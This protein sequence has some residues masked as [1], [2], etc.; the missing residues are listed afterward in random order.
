MP[1]LRSWE[2]LCWNIRGINSDDKQLALN[3]AIRTSG[4]SVV[5]IQE[6]KK[7]T[8]DLSFIKSCCPRQFDQFAYVPSQGASGG[9]L[10]IWKSSLFTS[11]VVFSS[12]FALVI[13]FTSTLSSHSW[14]LANIYGP[15]SG[16]ARITFTNWL[17]N[18]DIPSSQ[19]WLLVGDF[20][21]IRVPDNR[22]KPGGA[23]QT[24]AHSMILSAS[25][26][27]LSYLSR[28]D[29]L[30]GVTCKMIPCLSNSTGSSR[31]LIGPPPSQTRW[32]YLLASLFLIMS[33]AS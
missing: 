21:Y 7:T 19:D 3:N 4:C 18:L 23:H 2:V 20:N 6:T 8:F 26:A 29:R 14:T 33:L 28:A 5:C 1:L 17:Y 11:V 31:H 32:S 9:L 13:N 24:C 10:T 12:H 22:N 25:K 16:D 27:L 15:C 30:L